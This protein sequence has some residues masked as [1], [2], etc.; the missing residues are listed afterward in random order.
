MSVGYLVQALLCLKMHQIAPKM[1][2]IE[3]K[4]FKKFLGRGHSPLPGPLSHWVG[5]HPSPNPTLLFA[6]ILAPSALDLLPLHFHHLPPISHFWL[7]AGQLSFLSGKQ[8]SQFDILLTVALRITAHTNIKIN[9]NK[10]KDIAVIFSNNRSY[11]NFSKHD[12][13]FRMLHDVTLT[14]FYILS[15]VLISQGN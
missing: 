3:K 14:L 6:S 12:H 7:G 1:Q 15:V 11:S 13:N 9:S 10:V 5:G 8:L 2:Q 4:N